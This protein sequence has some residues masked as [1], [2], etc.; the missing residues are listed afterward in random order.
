MWITKEGIKMAVCDMETNH[1]KS[2]TAMMERNNTTIIIIGEHGSL[3]E[4]CWADEEPHPMY[5][6]LNEE[7][8]KRTGK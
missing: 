1:I 4:D 3:A 2:C 8:N 6:A 7:L 5:V